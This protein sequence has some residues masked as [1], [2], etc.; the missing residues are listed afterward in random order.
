MT[1]DHMY[2]QRAID[3]ARHGSGRVAPNPMVGA[4]IVLDYRIIGEGYHQNYGGPHAEVNAIDQVKN[5]ELL[6]EATIYVTLEPCAHH[7]KT[8]P[9]A[10]LLVRHQLKRVVIGCLDP[11]SKVNGKGIEILQKA[12][13]QVDTG[14]LEKECR[15]LNKRFFTFHERQRPYVILKWAQTKDGFLDKTRAENEMGINW[16]TAPETKVLVHKWRSEEQ[17]ILV[18]RK[19]VQ[20]DDPSLTVRELSGNNPIRVIIDSQLKLSPDLNVFSDDAPTLIFNRVKNEVKGNNE[21][22]KISETN[23][24][25]I[26][27]ELFKRNVLSVFVEGGSRT[28]QYFIFGNVWDEARVIIG[29]VHFGS[30][31]RAPIISKAPSET[32]AFGTD[33]VY[34][35]YRK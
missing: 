13:I 29:D 1:I 18:G 34:I 23:T 32:F 17:S 11:F 27:N 8:P 5:K 26:L 35:Y 24:E 22:I 12:G 2:M 30:G 21:W 16:I 3:L 9:C 6:K 7:G 4:V 25:L 28:L 15:E 33:Q 10:D 31:K 14:V 20:N 19:T